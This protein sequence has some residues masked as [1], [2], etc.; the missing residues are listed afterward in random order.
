MQWVDGMLSPL[1]HRLERLAPVSS[2]WATSGLRRKCYAITPAGRAALADREEPWTVVA[3]V[4]RQVRQAAQ[5][6]PTT[7][8]GRA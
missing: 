2:S 6:P 1:L 4:L 3:D 5:R 7:T 8:E